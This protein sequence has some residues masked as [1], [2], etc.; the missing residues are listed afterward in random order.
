[1]TYKNFLEKAKTILDII[2]D[3]KKEFYNQ[4]YIYD[5][6][7]GWD[8]KKNSKHN[9]LPYNSDANGNRK[10]NNFKSSKKNKIVIIGDSMVHG[11]EVGDNETWGF[12]L[13]KKLKKTNLINLGVSGYGNDQ[14]YLR[15]KRFLKKTKVKIAIFCFNS[16]N[17]LRNINIQ[18]LFLNNKGQFVY[19]KPRFINKGNKIK[20]IKIPKNKEKDYYLFLKSKKV[21]EHLKKYDF[22]YPNFF[23]NILKKILKTLSYSFSYN[24]YL[25]LSR[26]N[27]L[28]ITF[29]IFILFISLCK[30]NKIIP[31]ILFLPKLSGNFKSEKNLIYLKE[32]LEEKKINTF[33]PRDIFFN[34]EGKVIK[35]YFCD[36]NH[37]SKN[38]GKVLAE[39]IYNYIRKK[40]FFNI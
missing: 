11:D 1:M 40:N 25:L 24:H 6:E 36:K 38:G 5:N 32:K 39:T 37:Y 3:S 10:I 9:S 19:L 27:A 34:N 2:K 4:Y 22:F 14:A 30:K 8:I 35:K 33:Y 7:L 29:R 12:F 23:K 13:S 16:G 31:I 15:F 20:L 28:N 18:R 21:K 26:N 17:E